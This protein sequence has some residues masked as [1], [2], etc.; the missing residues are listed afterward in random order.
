VQGQ[1]NTPDGRVEVL[2][3]TVE[4]LT[5]EVT[6]LKLELATLVSALS[7]KILSRAADSGGRFSGGA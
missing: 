2:E 3:A 4:R 6:S 7:G 5:S 1:P